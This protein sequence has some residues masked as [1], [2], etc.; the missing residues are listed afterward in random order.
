[1]PGHDALEYHQL[2]AVEA[3]NGAIVVQIRNH[4]EP[5]RHELLQTESS[6]EGR[7]F[8][9]PST[10]DLDTGDLLT[11]WYDRQPHERDTRI[12]LLRWRWKA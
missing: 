11:L 3:A 8:G 9:Y 5:H 10:V 2:H 6:E 1:M 7:D 4:Q 12:H